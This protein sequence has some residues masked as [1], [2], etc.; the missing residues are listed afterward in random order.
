MV[1][2]G[3][4]VVVAP[5]FVAVVLFAVE[6]FL[7][8]VDLVAVDLVAVVR[9]YCEIAVVDCIGTVVL[10]AVAVVH[11]FVAVPVGVAA[12]GVVTGAVIGAKLLAPVVGKMPGMMGLGVS[13]YELLVC[14]LR[15]IHSATHSTDNRNAGKYHCRL[16]GECCNR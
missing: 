5:D 4:V 9:S 15:C 12:A 7:V 8:A 16:A 13:G 3:L 1:A 6:M 11:L 2:V 14:T 10:P